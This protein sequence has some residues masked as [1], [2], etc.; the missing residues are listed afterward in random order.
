M[1][2]IPQAN[3]FVVHTLAAVA[4][5]E[6][7]AI[8]KRTKAALQ[9]AKARGIEL[10]GRR[11]SAEKLAELGAV[12]RAARTQVANDS[13]AKVLPVIA[14]IQAA[15][16]TTLRQIAAELNAGGVAATV[17]GCQGVNPSSST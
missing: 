17:W 3:R 13:Y 10:A 6:A 16:A 14:E 7:E 4:E 9:A 15:G 1:R 2:S 11:V 5:Q 12:G 8:S